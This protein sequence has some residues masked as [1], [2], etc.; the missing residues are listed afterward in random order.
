M[1]HLSEWICYLAGALICLAWKWQRYC[2]ESRG[3]GIPFWKA[4]REWFEIHTLGSQ[5]SWAATVGV[6]WVIGAAYIERIGLEGLFGGVMTALPLHCSLA[7][8]IGA[9]AELI[10]PAAAKWLAAKIAISIDG[11]RQ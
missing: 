3:K 6:V 8:A 10:A 11:D 4:S 2:Y 9:F 7:F 1:Q 5:V